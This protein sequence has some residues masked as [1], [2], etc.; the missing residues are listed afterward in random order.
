MVIL[1]FTTLL[2]PYGEKIKD[3]FFMSLDTV[4]WVVGGICNKKYLWLL[5]SIKCSVLGV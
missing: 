2:R 5:S 3:F 4:N 1:D